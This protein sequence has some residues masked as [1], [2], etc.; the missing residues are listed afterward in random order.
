MSLL[1][2]EQLQDLYAWIDTVPLSRKKNNI[3]RDFSDGILTAEVVHHF[4]PRLVDM[5][6]YSP[7]NSIQHKTDNWR[8]LNSKL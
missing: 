3:T 5:H 8:A 4:I 2:E 1:N 7:A 6:N